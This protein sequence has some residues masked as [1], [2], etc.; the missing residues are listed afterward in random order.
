MSSQACCKNP[1]KQCQ[2]LLLGAASP[3]PTQAL[4]TSKMPQ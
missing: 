1:C 2:G 4:P 3:M